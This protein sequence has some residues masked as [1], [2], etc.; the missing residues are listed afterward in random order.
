MKQY[1]IT[2]KECGQRI[3]KY[4]KK[5]LND[6]PLSFI[7]K[8][9]R[10]KDVKI[11]GHWVKQDYILQ[12]GETLTIY[13]TDEQMESF[14]TLDLSKGINMDLD[15]VYEDENIMIINKEKGVLVHDVD[16]KEKRTLSNG[17]LTYLINKGEYNP[18]VD[19]GF[20]PGPAHRLDRN[21]SGLVIFGKNL[22]TLQCLQREFRNKENIEKTYL[23]L[24]VG[25]LKDN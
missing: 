2:H 20:T 21:T 12:D 13:V 6:A 22:P 10:K 8:L 9:F 5:L 1:L 17:V 14:H 16:N 4:V 18:R 3:D 23:S 24:V 11:D 25:S 15:I 7:Y 19:I